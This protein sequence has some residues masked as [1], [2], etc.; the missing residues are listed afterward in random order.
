MY[1]RGGTGGHGLARYNGI[2]G[3]GGN[4]Y[5]VARERATL[6]NLCRLFPDRRF[7]AATGGDSRYCINA[8]SEECDAL[9][10]GLG[11][12]LHS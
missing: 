7:C 1:V 9:Q 10:M 12:S 6:K 8:V 4:V 11:I 5:V 3:R 2:G